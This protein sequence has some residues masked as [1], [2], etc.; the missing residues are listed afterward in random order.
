M[1]PSPA[2]GPVVQRPS[3]GAADPYRW[4]QESSPAEIARWPHGRGQRLM[5]RAVA[6]CSPATRLCRQRLP[7]HQ[8]AVPCVSGG[9][10][11]P[12]LRAV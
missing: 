1:K 6:R 9:N 7:H 5:Q 11:L 12:R 3:A 2:C 4:A 10:C 8:S